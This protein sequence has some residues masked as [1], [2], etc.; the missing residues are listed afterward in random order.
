MKSHPR[1][2]DVMIEYVLTQDGQEGPRHIQEYK[3]Q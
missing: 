2:Y 1:S 3:V